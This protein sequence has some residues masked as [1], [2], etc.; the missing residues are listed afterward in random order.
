M[1]RPACPRAAG[2]ARTELWKFSH[3]PSSATRDTRPPMT[4][5]SMTAAR[6]QYPLDLLAPGPG[7]AEEARTPACAGGAAGRGD[8]GGGCGV[9]VVRRDRAVGRRCRPEGALILPTACWRRVVCRPRRVLQA[10]GEVDHGTDAAVE[11]TA[12]MPGTREA[13]ASA[14]SS[15]VTPIRPLPRRRHER[16]SPLQEDHRKHPQFLHFSDQCSV[17]RL[18]PP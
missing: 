18:S 10:E 13:Q 15:R 11:M 14:S 17:P 2:R 12:R 16:R 9:T 5:S 6:S 7:P 3:S 8:R 4:S 1:M